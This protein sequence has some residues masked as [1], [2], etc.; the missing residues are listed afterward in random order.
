[1]IVFSKKNKTSLWFLSQILASIAE[2]RLYFIDYLNTGN[3][4]YWDD[5]LPS[6]LF[7]TC[8]CQI[9]DRELMPEKY[10]PQLRELIKK[11]DNLCTAIN[12]KK[13]ETFTLLAYFHQ[14]TKNLFFSE[15]KRHKIPTDLISWNPKNLESKI[16]EITEHEKECDPGTFMEDF[17]KNLL[18]KE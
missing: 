11:H 12:N 8:Y 2:T 15:L 6:M 4:N 17:K 3:K 16:I 18:L 10:F 13:E 5:M 1:M 7:Q 14:E 9:I